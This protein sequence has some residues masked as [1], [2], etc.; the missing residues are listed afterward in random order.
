LRAVTADRSVG[1]ADGK[2]PL[3][4]GRSRTL[5]PRPSGRYT[6]IIVAEHTTMKRSK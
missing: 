1:D 6:K 3:A 5:P 2:P 4:T